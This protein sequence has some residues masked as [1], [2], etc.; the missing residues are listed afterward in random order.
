MKFD[1]D[2]DGAKAAWRRSF[3]D[4]ARAL[5]AQAM[6]EPVLGAWDVHKKCRAL[7]KPLPLS[8][9]KLRKPCY[10]YPLYSEATKRLKDYTDKAALLVKRKQELTKAADALQESKTELNVLIAESRDPAMKN[11]IK[12]DVLAQAKDQAKQ[13]IAACE[14]AHKQAQAAVER[15]QLAIAGYPQ[16]ERQ[17][18]AFVQAVLAQL[19]LRP[20]TKKLIDIESTGNG[21]QGQNESAAALSTTISTQ[22]TGLVDIALSSEQETEPSSFDWKTE[23]QRIIVPGPFEA[24]PVITQRSKSQHMTIKPFSVQADAEA[25]K[26]EIELLRTSKQRQA[27]EEVGACS[28]DAEGSGSAGQSHAPLNSILPGDGVVDAN[29]TALNDAVAPIKPVPSTPGAV[30]INPLVLQTLTL[31]CGKRTAQKAGTTGLPISVRNATQDAE[32]ASSGALGGLLTET[33]LPPV[34]P[35]RAVSTSSL[36]TDPAPVNDKVG[37]VKPSRSR[38]LRRLMGQLSPSL[39]SE[40][41]NDKT[42]SPSSRPAGQF[43]FLERMNMCA[44]AMPAN[45][46]GSRIKSDPIADGKSGG[47]LT[48]LDMIK[49]RR[50]D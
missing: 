47:A 11:V 33:N 28:D 1:H 10:W 46:P 6:Q 45:T 18:R 25:R 23:T 29:I 9:D 12:A 4:R 41:S 44:N 48:F 22:S 43:T 39:D 40:P 50:Q 13:D 24:E 31:M 2:P 42:D 14:T 16:T 30:K 34:T 17:Y 32:P 8:Q 36:L 26:A 35:Q 15:I 49:K 19:S 5:V 3:F 27:Q 7:V 20:A 38:L 37:T 21:A